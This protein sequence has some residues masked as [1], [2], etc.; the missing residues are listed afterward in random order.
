MRMKAI[1]PAGRT[2]HR[3]P[4]GGEARRVALL[5][6]MQW[7]MLGS[8][9]VAFIAL[10]STGRAASS[11]GMY[12]ALI[13][14]LTLAVSCALT[15]NLAGFFR[16]SATLTVAAI[17]VPPW[18]SLALDPRVL[19]GDLVP[20]AYMVFPV[21]ISAMLL[22]I[23]AVVLMSGLQWT[24]LLLVAV[25]GP[26]TNFNWPSLLTLVFVVTVISTA[27]CAI[28][29][30]DLRQIDDQVRQLNLIQAELRD[31]AVHDSLTGLFNRSYLNDQLGR[32][33]ERSRRTGVPL[34]VVMIDIDHFKIFNDQL[35][36]AGGDDALLR[37][38]RALTEQF[39]ASDSACRLGG[40]EFIVVMPEADLAG[41]L[42]RAEG[43]C[44]SFDVT[45]APP[46]G[47]CLPVLTL[48]VGIAVF[49]D[50]ADTA[51]HLLAAADQALY[52]AKNGGRN[53]VAIASF[54]GDRS[55]V[56]VGPGGRVR[57]AADR[58]GVLQS[59]TRD[60]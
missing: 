26:H 39:R 41:T 23:R 32:E 30:T 56:L 44:A 59:V 19:Q 5:R 24:A 58:S 11:R 21:M 13:V 50:H 46:P 7:L 6:N 52:E 9:A 29:R 57:T 40:D 18:F 55:T 47:S 12:T 51:D 4:S 48:S 37:V 2:G 35:G 15:L 60:R 17:S 14:G 38:A 34:G 8:F 42:A 49:P 16:M 20:L 31:Q 25:L 22:S 45:R 27:Y 36:H 10:L 33:I 43:L 53:K 1:G 54:V 28:T 3:A